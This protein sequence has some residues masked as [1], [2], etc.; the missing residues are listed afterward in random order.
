MGKRECDR[1]FPRGGVHVFC[2][3]SVRRTSVV[4]VVECL[5]YPGRVNVAYL[6]RTQKLGRG[7]VFRTLLTHV[8]MLLSTGHRCFDLRISALRTEVSDTR[9]DEA[10]APEY[11]CCRRQSV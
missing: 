9:V 10:L 1:R 3:S 8:H 2:H 11:C 6:I 7:Q 5:A 4:C